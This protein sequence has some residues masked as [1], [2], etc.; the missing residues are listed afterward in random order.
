MARL[1]PELIISELQRRD[2]LS[3][4]KWAH[5]Y[6]V[7]CTSHG[8]ERMVIYDHRG[9]PIVVCSWAV[10]AR[11]ER[12]VRA[13]HIVRDLA[14]E[15]PV[16]R[17]LVSEIL[18]A[19]SIGPR[20]V[21]V[22]RWYPGT[23]LSDTVSSSSQR[24][25]ALEAAFGTLMLLHK[26]TWEP[27]LFSEQDYEAYVAQPIRTLEGSVVIPK[28]QRE[29][30]AYLAYRLRSLVGEAVPSCV[31]HGDF[32]LDNLLREREGGV[33]VL[34]WELS[35]PHGLCFMDLVHLLVLFSVKG[36]GLSYGVS[37]VRMFG[38]GGALQAWSEPY[39]RKYQGAMGIARHATGRLVALTA[40]YDAASYL[41]RVPFLIRSDFWADYID[42]ADHL[43]S[44]DDRAPND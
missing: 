19:E 17:S 23:M 43:L 15:Y 30:L 25:R 3:S 12:L 26:T 39:R 7:E 36:F 21:A 6:I 42:A 34:D 4:G 31:F 24:Q 27:H 1:F 20:F 44:D 32:Q 22:W 11:L 18:L 37:T 2:L 16:L 14:S 13:A 41:V 33:R 38:R 10:G 9:D 29:R 8:S 5:S 28:P 40:L 35:D